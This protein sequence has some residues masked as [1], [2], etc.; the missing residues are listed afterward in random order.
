MTDMHGLRGWTSPS[1]EIEG[2]LLL[3]CIQDLVHVSG[4]GKWR[5]ESDFY[6]LRQ[7]T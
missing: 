7:E 5:F 6:N 4:S 3:I 2:L 1:V